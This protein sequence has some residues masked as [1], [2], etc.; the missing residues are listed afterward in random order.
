MLCLGGCA[1][2]VPATGDGSEPPD[3]AVGDSPAD[4]P[5]VTADEAAPAG[6]APED[7]PVDRV[8]RALE[9]GLSLVG[10]PY[11][12]WYDGPLPPSAPM[13]TAS[14]A[15]PN[16]AVVRAESANCTGLTNLMLRSVGAPMPETV[17]GGRGGT[18]S[19]HHALAD[20]AQPFDVD[21][22]YPP[23]TLLGR[24]YRDT[25]DQGHV[26]VVLPDG[27]VLQS[28]AW[29]RDATA[30]GVNATY[31]VAESDDGGFYEY[32]VLPQDWLGRD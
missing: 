18:Y 29:E 5:G 31:T 17:D 15:A 8:A 20:V 4:A 9:Y 28:F 23:G 1:M 2:E 11:G 3:E 21:A 24:A 7:E 19:Y 10:T 27:H 14:G 26:A 32:A 30:P 25:F 6:A 16:A 12:W 13:W 22:D